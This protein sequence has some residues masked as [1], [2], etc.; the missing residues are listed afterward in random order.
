MLR[1]CHHNSCNDRLMHQP[2]HT[3]HRA[4]H[5]NRIS[6]RH[7]AGGSAASLLDTAMHVSDVA[8]GKLYI[9][10]VDEAQLRSACLMMTRVFAAEERFS[11]DDATQF[12]TQVV[13]ATASG[14]G[15]VLAARLEPTDPSLLPPNQTT[16]LVGTVTLSFHPDTR[17]EFPTLPP[18]TSSAY[19]SNM[20]VEQKLRRQG[21]A[22]AMLEAC[23]A[24]ARSAGHSEMF[25]HVRQVDTGAQEL[26]KG[27]G[28]EEVSRDGGLAVFKLQGKKPRI[29]MSKGL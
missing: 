10:P 2:A 5:R 14:K 18:P 17:Q 4:C 11:M 1:W 13:E 21:I 22:K 20:A 23:D 9:V 12:T 27:A 15:L 28:Y 29:L 8:T 24:A 25:L 3:N 19:L 7:V 16:R 6:R 26:Y